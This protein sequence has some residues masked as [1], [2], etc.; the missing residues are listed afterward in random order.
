MKTHAPRFRIAR[1]AGALLG[2]ALS[3]AATTATA[4]DEPFAHAKRNYDTYCVQ[5]HGVNRNGRGV[6]SRDMSVQ[7]RDHSDAKGMGGIP[8]EEIAKVIKEGGLAA[9]K[10]VLMPAWGNVLSDDEIKEMVAYLRHV[11]NCGSGK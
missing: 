9:N 6:N 8:D 11:C 4:A 5:C 3:V 1:L 2:A 10:S 7:P